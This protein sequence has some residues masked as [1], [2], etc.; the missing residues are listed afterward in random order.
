M[1]FILEYFAGQL[2][3]TGIPL[4]AGKWTVI[5]VLFLAQAIGFGY[6]GYKL[7]AHFKDIE[8][9]DLE[10]K[11]KAANDEI[12]AMITAAK[13]QKD[14]AETTATTKVTEIKQVNTK[15]QEVL[16]KFIDGVKNRPEPPPVILEPGVACTIDKVF[17]ATFLDDINHIHAILE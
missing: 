16:G 4:A 6:L 13:E 1:S 3:K 5:L 2:L 14:T 11:L 7:D 8:I 9:G 15:K 17:D 10:I 12:Q